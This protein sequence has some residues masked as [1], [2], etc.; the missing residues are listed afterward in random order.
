ME[1]PKPLAGESTSSNGGRMFNFQAKNHPP[2]YYMRKIMNYHMSLRNYRSLEKVLRNYRSNKEW[3]E[4]FVAMKG[5]MA[6]A[7][8]LLQISQRT[9]KSND[10]LDKEFTILTAIRDIMTFQEKHEGRIHM[11]DVN[12][13]VVPSLLSPRIITRNTATNMLALSVAYEKEEAANSITRGLTNTTESLEMGSTSDICSE[14]SASPENPFRIWMS[15]AGELV[16]DFESENPNLVFSDEDFSRG[17]LTPQSIIKE[18]ALMTVF[19]VSSLVSTC[20]NAKSRAVMRKKFEDAGL[21]KLFDYTKSL[22]SDAINDLVSNYIALRSDDLNG[23]EDPVISDAPPKINDDPEEINMDADSSRVDDDSVGPYISNVVKNLISVKESK[24]RAE[25]LKYLRMIDTLVVNLVNMN[26]ISD[27]NDLFTTQLLLDRLS[28]DDTARLALSEAH[29]SAHLVQEYKRRIV[30]LEEELR[31]SNASSGPYS[32]YSPKDASGQKFSPLLASTRDTQSAT[33][34]RS[35][36][37]GDGIRLQARTDIMSNNFSSS[38][39][40]EPFEHYDINSLGPVSKFGSSG[41]VSD[42]GES[43]RIYKTA[44]EGRGNGVRDSVNRSENDG[45]GEG[46]HFGFKFEGPQNTDA[47]S[48]LRSGGSLNASSQLS[49]FTNAPDAPSAPPLPSFLQPAAPS[50]SGMSPSSLP[51]PPPPPPPPFLLELAHQ[52][53]RP[54]AVPPAPPLPKPFPESQGKEQT[55]EKKPASIPPPPPP[56]PVFPKSRTEDRRPI[57]NRKR[58]DLPSNPV[59]NLLAM[60]KPAFKMKHLHWDKI[61]DISDTFWSGV[62]DERVISML[63]KAGVLKDMDITF[64]AVDTPAK[65]RQLKAKDD[66]PKKM[67]LLPRELQQQFG[68]NLHQY[69]NLSEMEFVA[70]V[71]SCDRTLL[72]NTTVIEFFNWDGLLDMSASLLSK[73]GPYSTNIQIEGAKPKLDPSNLARFDRIYLELCVNLRSYWAARSKALLLS[74]TY[75]RDY[76]DL[77]KRL[78]QMD[79]GISSIRGSESLLQVFN[80]IKNIGNYLNESSKVVSGFKLSGLQRLKFLKNS[81]NTMTLLHYIEKIIRVHFPD[82]AVFVDDLKEISKAAGLLVSTLEVEASEYSAAVFKCDRSFSEGPL[83]EGSRIHPDDEIREYMKPKLAKAR[84]R[85]NFLKDHM[86]RTSKDF[87]RLMIYFGENPKDQ[88][89][90]ESFFGKF[91]AFTESYKKAHTENVR[92]EE[93]AKTYEV[94][95]KMMEEFKNKKSRDRERLMAASSNSRGSIVIEDLL[96]QLKANH[97]ITRKHSEYHGR[98]VEHQDTETITNKAQMMLRDLEEVGSDEDSLAGSHS[99]ESVQ[100]FDPLVGDNH[101][102]DTKRLEISTDSTS[103]SSNRLSIITMLINGSAGDEF[104]ALSAGED[105]VR[106]DSMGEMIDDGITSNEKKEGQEGEA[107]DIGRHVS[108]GPTLPLIVN[109]EEQRKDRDETNPAQKILPFGTDSLDMAIKHVISEITMTTSQ[110]K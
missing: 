32:E 73:F 9:I 29:E 10:Q 81:K 44:L 65:S 20:V 62:D 98:K 17:R 36:R 88:A 28:T 52:D 99:G 66:T 84:R 37:K 31:Q 15:S 30:Q 90:R 45:S 13:Y 94:R 53:G 38:T 3:I 57:V 79:R 78:N 74:S 21:I 54:A 80:I 47:G 48:G 93:E 109:Y 41:S 50:P 35:Y 71:L 97:P 49:I 82:L 7:V 108:P 33:E 5:H 27:Q 69:G 86:L 61:H 96:S 22:R 40:F 8:V 4:E 100:D 56:L 95:K 83:S 75:E 87:D 68:I 70:K 91:A 6:L 11:A 51:P 110:G 76:H 102:A 14:N 107:V 85:A 18:Y 39:Y 23:A 106:A 77:L 26:N 34:L 42:A 60:K 63:D 92:A 2:V 64:K 55:E 19:L 12:R 105:S 72:E 89:S 67:A 58:E 46:M 104:D 103:K 1:V 24:N 43:D 16:A 101:P 25:S 59:I